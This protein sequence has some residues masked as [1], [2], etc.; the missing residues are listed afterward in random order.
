MSDLCIFQM[1]YYSN[2]IVLNK[3]KIAVIKTVNCTHTNIKYITSGNELV[4]SDK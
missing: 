3:K 4:F 1:Y 2:V